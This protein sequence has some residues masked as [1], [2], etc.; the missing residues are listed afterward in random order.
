MFSLGGW[1][2][3]YQSHLQKLYSWA[4]HWHSWWLVNFSLL[5]HRRCFIG[6][7]HCATT[8]LDVLLLCFSCC[9]GL[10]VEQAKSF[11]PYEFLGPL[12]LHSGL[13]SMGEWASSFYYST[14]SNYSISICC[15][16]AIFSVLSLFRNLLEYALFCQNP[17]FMCSE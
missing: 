11:Y 13:P 10:C 15:I 17:E 8:V 12:Y 3:M 4:I 9:T 2:H 6:Y 7:S 14:F 5:T 16:L 1:Y